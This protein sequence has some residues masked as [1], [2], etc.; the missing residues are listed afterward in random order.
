MQQLTLFGADRLAKRP[1]CTDDPTTG[2]RIR[3][4]AQAL[5]HSHI[6]ANS[7]ALRWRLVF[8]I[9]RPGAVFAAEDGGVATPNWTSESAQNGHAHVGYEV[10]TALVTSEAGRL[11]PLR[12]AAAIEHAYMTKLGADISYVGLI[13][14]N[15]LH[16][17]WRTTV[18][19]V[20]P[21][22]LAELAEWVDLPSR[23]PK[24]QLAESPLGR[25]VAVFDRL[26]QWAYRNVKRYE[27]SAE[28]K[29]A[30]LMQATA[31]NSSFLVA[32]PDNEVQHIA[33]SVAK[34]TWTRF[35]TDA[36]D[37]RFSKLQAHRGTLS[38]KSRAVK[39]NARAI[40]AQSMSAQ[41]MTQKAIAAA[42]GVSQPTVS[43][44]LN[45]NISEP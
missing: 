2:L 11:E 22:D 36:S 15:P 37:A 6:Q 14:K 16:P 38:G 21:Y 10:E 28:W 20:Q 12:F 31:F 9:D 1:Y 43:A 27:D 26:R 19:R 42:L 39:A 24:K 41:G 8:D 25:N 4:Q 34:W 13:C 35:D 33:K 7:P 5:T 40:E 29:F 18:H 3:G 30:C 45:R 23:I 17:K 44:L 32:L